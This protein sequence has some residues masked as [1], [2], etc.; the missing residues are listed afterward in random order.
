M[1]STVLGSWQLQLSPAPRAVP[2]LITPSWPPELR[3]HGCWQHPCVGAG[4]PGVKADGPGVRGKKGFRAAPHAA[5][6]STEAKFRL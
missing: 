3:C 1:E 4:W 6:R 5:P 2:Q